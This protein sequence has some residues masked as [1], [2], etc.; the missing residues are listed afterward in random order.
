MKVKP[1]AVILALLLALAGTLSACGGKEETASGTST[2]AGEESAT[3]GNPSA[4]ETTPAEVGKEP[5][6]VAVEE[7]TTS[8]PITKSGDP[9]R[10]DADSAVKDDIISDLADFLD[11]SGLKNL[12]EDYNGQYTDNETYISLSF[13]LNDSSKQT[14]AFS[15]EVQIDG[16]VFS[17]PIKAEDFEAAGWKINNESNEL[18]YGYQTF[19][20][21]QN[22]A[23]GHG[24]YGGVW[25]DRS[26]DELNASKGSVCLVQLEPSRYP[27]TDVVMFGKLTK[28]SS[29]ADVIAALGEP[30]LVYFTIRYNSST[31]AFESCECRLEYNVPGRSSDSFDFTIDIDT[32]QV[33]QIELS[34]AFPN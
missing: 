8:A 11:R 6:T 15:P 32:N 1:I 34:I 3:A 18:K 7:R 33:K 12:A 14:F 27:D 10:A 2:A 26:Q 5:V 28:G 21:F 16:A 19:S 13:V 24:L 25:N 9:H 23:T 29:V 4:Q 22:D 20:T 17:L 31:G 30:G